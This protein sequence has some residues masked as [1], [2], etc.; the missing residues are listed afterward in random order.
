MEAPPPAPA[1]TND[2]LPFTGERFVPGTPGEIWVEHWHRYH[3]A[4]RWTAGKRV[5]DVA[6]GE[7]YGSALLAR[8]A[9]SVTGIDV[10]EAAIAHARRTYA[11]VPNLQLVRASCDALPL[12]DASVDVAVSFET[13]EHIAEQAAFLDELARV[14]AP[15]GVLVLSCPNKREY[16]DERSH[17]NEFHV[18]E[19]YREE[20]AALVSA[21]FPESDW[22]GQRPTFYS[23][24][25]PEAPAAA[26]GQ[27]VEVEEADPV[28]ARPAL[29]RP[30]YFLVAASRERSAL[31]AVPRALSVLADRGD[32]VYRDYENT[33]RKLRQAEI[34][35]EGLQAQLQEGHRVLQQREA[36]IVAR[37]LQLSERNR[38][39]VRRRGWRAWL[40]LPLERLGL[41]K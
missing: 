18:K 9:A 34:G 22:Y 37:G 36:E 32:W 8:G 17:V 11:D 25:A 29:S 21:R 40:R 26:V 19:L 5:V 41:L 33:Y 35:I 2:A 27:V 31:D 15:G 12:A 4:A 39:I 24:I 7:G 3:F 16:S 30:L 38:E 10:S 14:L 1:P 28:N 6:C 13:L 23:M 20:L